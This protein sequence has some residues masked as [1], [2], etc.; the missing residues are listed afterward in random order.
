MACTDQPCYENLDVPLVIGFYSKSG[1]QIKDTVLDSLSVIAG[2]ANYGLKYT[3]ASQINQFPNPDADQTTFVFF[4]DTIYEQFYND[5]TQ[6][7]DSIITK[8]VID[9]VTVQYQTVPHLV[10]HNCGFVMFFEKLNV[11]S[12]SKNYIDT[13]VVNQPTLT[14]EPMENLQIHF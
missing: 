3:N 1:L 2:G 12:Y 7:V 14:N 5:T 11:V 4:M 10:S 8:E 6:A 13:I 9:E